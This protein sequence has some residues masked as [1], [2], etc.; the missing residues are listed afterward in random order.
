MNCVASDPKQ[1]DQTT[2]EQTSTDQTCETMVWNNSSLHLNQCPWVSV[3]VTVSESQS[4]PW[5]WRE[6]FNSLSSLSLME[7]VF[8]VA[9]K[10]LSRI[11]K[12]SLNL[13]SQQIPNEVHEPP[14]LSKCS[15]HAL[16]KEASL[17]SKWRP[18]QQ[19]TIGHRVE[20][21]G[22]WGDHHNGYI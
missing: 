19:I 5:L 17:R 16:I 18:S 11:F 13:L 10:I 15:Y 4:A 21:I 22:L 1:Q 14:F 7:S 9:P 2:M 6:R 3:M 8:D 20:I 12:S